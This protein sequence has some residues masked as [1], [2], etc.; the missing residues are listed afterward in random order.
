MRS[1][2]S[3]KERLFTSRSIVR[4]LMGLVSR[5]VHLGGKAFCCKWCLRQ[6]FVE[7]K[8]KS[9]GRNGELGAYPGI[10]LA[11]GTDPN[12]GSWQ[13]CT[14]YLTIAFTMI[15]AIF[16]R[17]GPCLATDMTKPTVEVAHPGPVQNRPCPT[18]RIASLPAPVLPLAQVLHGYA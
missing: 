3:L 18:V 7:I 4:W 1:T 11:L 6:K 2:Q 16:S 10:E 14:G 5:T 13:W 12:I 17:D 15:A 9:S 8:L